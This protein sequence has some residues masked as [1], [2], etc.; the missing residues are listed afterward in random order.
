MELQNVSEASD[1]MDRNCLGHP[2][3]AN[4]S[5]TVVGDKSEGRVGAT[6][7]KAPY[8]LRYPVEPLIRC[9]FCQENGVNE[10]FTSPV[11]LERHLVSAH[12]IIETAWECIV[13]R[14]R[15]PRKQGVANHY[16][17]KCKN[18][19]PIERA[20]MADP[21]DEERPG[22]QCDQCPEAFNVKAGVSQ[23]KRHNHPEVRTRERIEAMQR[24]TRQNL[25]PKQKANK[26][27]TLEEEALLL[28]LEKRFAGKRYI[29]KEIQTFLPQYT[30]KQISDKRRL[31]QAARN[32]YAGDD[33]PELHPLGQSLNTEI[34]T[35][36]DQTLIMRSYRPEVAL[37]NDLP[38]EE[39]G[40]KESLAASA[41]RTFHKHRQSLR[42]ERK[43]IGERLEA[44]ANAMR[45]QEDPELREAL[46]HALEA[47]I[48]LVSSLCA[49]KKSGA[50]PTPR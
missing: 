27:W 2:N 10:S 11:T 16:K 3:Q 28:V 49:P 38:T 7:H 29:N 44:I 21:Q 31:L 36:A 17:I 45:L 32:Q 50:Q 4:V 9:N 22:H 18:A 13:C 25:G 19:L 41:V 30:N 39:R 12:G 43:L 42:G 37:P 6:T 5:S 40:W 14:K 1:G 24:S 8:I 47:E 20:P 23:H 33:N 34:D 35:D 15:Y 46:T 26:L 48:K